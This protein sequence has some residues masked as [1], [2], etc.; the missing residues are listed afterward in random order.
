MRKI[1]FLVTKGTWGG[2]QKYVFDIATRLSGGQAN[3]PSDRFDVVV[4]Y[5]TK[6]KL[7]EDLTNAGIRT[8][9]LPSLSRDVAFG[10]DFNSFFE[11][12]RL[13][14]SERPD[15]LHL[16]SSKAA[17][18]GALAGRIAGIPKIVF[19][20]HGW[21]FREDRTIVSK[22]LIWLISWF[23]ALLATDVICVSD[24]DLRQAKRM[25][26]I[27]KKS[28][29]IYNGIDLHTQFGSGEIIRSKFP[30][31]ANITGTVGELTKNKNQQALI[32]QAKNDPSMYVAIVGI[33]GEAKPMLESLIA[34][35]G[36]SERVKLFGYIPASDVLKGFDT[37]ALPSIKEG[38]PY[39][40]IEARLAGLPIVANRVG[41]VGEILEANDLNE[42][43]LDQM[44]KKTTALYIKATP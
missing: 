24:F 39:V 26:F 2:A 10:S 21:P 13:L 17:A 36:L 41:G 37:F 3:L 22:A 30:A 25:P 31:G 28:V 6:G 34:Q 11:I 14:R 5:G 4:A 32:E 42:F 40:L 16:N 35:Y 23:T 43:S 29:R 8:F 18:I 20:V 44:L 1:L 12:R 38:L 27:G 9:Q 19:T 33:E 15:V 7:A